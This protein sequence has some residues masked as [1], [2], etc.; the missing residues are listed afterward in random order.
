MFYRRHHIKTSTFIASTLPVEM[1][2]LEGRYKKS[3]FSLRKGELNEKKCKETK[4]FENEC[5][6]E[7]INSIYT[8]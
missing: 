1:H 4:L 6:R 3:P 5:K 8:S 7:M 2:L